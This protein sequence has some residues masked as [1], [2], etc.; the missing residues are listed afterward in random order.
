MLKI[1]DKKIPTHLHS[2]FLLPR[3]M[4]LDYKDKDGGE[5]WIVFMPLSW[6]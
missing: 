5:V 1:L 4:V 2:T 3:P 6:V